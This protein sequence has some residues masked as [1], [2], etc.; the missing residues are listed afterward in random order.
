M[1]HLSISHENLNHCSI[2]HK[3]LQHF[4]YMGMDTITFLKGL[5]DPTKMVNLLAYHTWFTQ[6][7]RLPLKRSAKSMTPMIV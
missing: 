6:A 2:Q 1:Q 7:S 4:Q 5:R 3:L